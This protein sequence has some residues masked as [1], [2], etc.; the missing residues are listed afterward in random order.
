MYFLP[1]YFVFLA[2]PPSTSYSHQS[3]PYFT[4]LNITLSIWMQITLSMFICIH[5]WKI[6]YLYIYLTTETRS[7]RMQITICN[8]GQILHPNISVINAEVLQ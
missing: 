3:S 5:I 2:R 7:M 1:L 6:V 4:S 8:S